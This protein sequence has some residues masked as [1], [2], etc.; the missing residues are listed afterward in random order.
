[1]SKLC[2]FWAAFGMFAL[3]SGLNQTPVSANPF[4]AI[5]RT[6]YNINNTVNSVDHTVRNTNG[7]V[8]NLSD[9][10]G[11]QSNEPGTSTTNTNNNAQSNTKQILGIYHTWYKSLSPSDQE[12]VAKLIME[13]AQDKQVS[14]STLS[15]NEWFTQKDLQEQQKIGSI[16]L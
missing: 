7:T 8:K 1:M 9:T 14:F 15:K 3:C 4:N 10:L 6:L 5:N 12:T 16:F 13:Y 11:I 2:K